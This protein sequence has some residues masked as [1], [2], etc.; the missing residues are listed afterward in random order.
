M[1]PTTP[2]VPRRPRFSWIEAEPAAE[3]IAA[4]SDPKFNPL[5]HSDLRH[6]PGLEVASLLVGSAGPGLSGPAVSTRSAAA[7]AGA[8]AEAA[9]ALL[10]VIGSGYGLPFAAALLAR[11]GGDVKEA[12]AFLFDGV[13]WIGMAMNH[14]PSP[15]EPALKKRVEASLALAKKLSAV[16][17]ENH[18]SAAAA[19]RAGRARP[20]LNP[21]LVISN[22]YR[23]CFRFFLKLPWLR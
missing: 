3:A 12:A 4:R 1:S 16:A 6:M 22:K 13:E 19:G 14:S 8:G 17:L 5:R 20:L 10:Q 21:H 18:E 7:K 23:A 9:Q 2:T 11:K 15:L